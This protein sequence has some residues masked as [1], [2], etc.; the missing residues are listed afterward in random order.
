M[1]R[2]ANILIT[3]F[4]SIIFTI[5]TFAQNEISIF[6]DGKKLSL[7]AQPTIVNDTTMVPMRAIFESMAYTV[8][9]DNT[10]KTVTGFKEGSAIR[11]Q[12]NN[13]TATLN[14]K[15]ISLPVE[16]YIMDGY[17]L[18]PLRFVAESSG[19]IVEWESETTS[20]Q[21]YSQL[22]YAS[23]KKNAE[24]SIDIEKLKENVVTVYTNK[25]QGS[26]VIL[27]PDGYIATNFHVIEGAQDIWISFS[28]G[29][30]YIDDVY[31]AGYDSPMDIAILKINSESSSYAQI[32]D[33]NTLSEGDEVILIGSPL[34]I[35]N[36]VTKGN[37][38]FSDENEISSSAK[39]DHGSSGGGMFNKYGEI[40]GV[41]SAFL[42][43]GTSLA[44]P[45]GLVAEIKLDKNIDMENWKY[46][47]ADLVPPRH[48]DFI[49][50]EDKIYLGWTSVYSAD[51]YKVYIS[52]SKDGTY[53]PLKNT[54]NK[55]QWYWATP[56]SLTIKNLEYINPYIKVSVVRN[57]VESQKSQAFKLER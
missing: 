17:T 45:I 48:V 22:Y 44:I 4:L 28:N 39:I 49:L 53:E 9:W 16:P 14:G 7:G 5:P 6:Y 27:S 18:V 24:K 38:I 1:K 33:S 12:L 55:N 2:I 40:V 29:L 36:T 15:E 19:S 35:S 56:F 25:F 46:V 54:D 47:K 3:L 34:G 8:K 31:I 42:Q 57:G 20:I 21:I 26:G 10:T 23:L 52:N 41:T 32:A 13:Q 30:K 37:I 50:K 43:N 11:L 51:Y